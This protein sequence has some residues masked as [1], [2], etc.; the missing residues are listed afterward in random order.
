MLDRVLFLCIDGLERA[1]DTGR[2]LLGINC[3]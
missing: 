2:A 1:I 3:D